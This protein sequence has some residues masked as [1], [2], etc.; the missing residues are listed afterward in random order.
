MKNRNI[1]CVAGLLAVVGLAGCSGG[2]LSAATVAV[3]P[4]VKADAEA[5]ID[6]R[7]ESDALKALRHERL[8]QFDRAIQ[9]LAEGE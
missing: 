2:A 8:N 9:V 7:D 6:S 4:A 3:W 5:G 1:L